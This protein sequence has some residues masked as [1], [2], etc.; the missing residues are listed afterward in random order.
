[1]RRLG[2]E[3]TTLN[4]VCDQ[5][6][7][8]TYAR[9]LAEAISLI[10]PQIDETNSGIYHFSNEGTCSWYDFAVEIM[11]LSNID[12]KVMPI[13]SSQYPTK[14]VRP[15]YSVL[16]KSKI[17]ETFNVKIPYW[18]ESLISCLKLF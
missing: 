13:L 10:V 12:C 9:D 1:M 5:T 8:P 16:D 15:F 6:G 2:S 17:K 4:V 11:K 3:R 7:T 14:A 18:K